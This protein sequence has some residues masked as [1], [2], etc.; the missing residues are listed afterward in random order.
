MSKPL[1]DESVLGLQRLYAAAGFMP[2]ALDGIWGPKTEAASREWDAEYRRIRD[3]RGEL[4]SRSER[5]IVTLLPVFQDPLREFLAGLDYPE[6]LKGGKVKVLSGTRSYKEQDALF[7]KGRSKP[8]KPV[9]NARGGYSN[10]NFGIACDLG[11]FDKLGAYITEKHP[12]FAVY[13]E[14]GKVAASAVHLTWGGTWKSFQDLPHYQL[15]TSLELEDLRTRFEAGVPLR[16]DR[17]GR[18]L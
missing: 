1:S 8:G 16:V 2:G 17:R 6:L 5:C 18:A 7:T 13:A 4:D 11:F 15:N 10:H 12:D 3:A 14:A 9:T